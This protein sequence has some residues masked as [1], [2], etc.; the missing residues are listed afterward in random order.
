MNIDT[1]KS[2]PEHTTFVAPAWGLT[3]LIPAGTVLAWGARAIYT[4]RYV[5]QRVRGK[6]KSTTFEPSIDLVWD[7]QGWSSH[8]D[9]PD[10]EA[11][12]AMALWINEHGIPAITRQCRGQ[13][14][15]PSDSVVLAF[16]GSGYAIKASPNSSYGYL[17]IA[18]WRV[19]P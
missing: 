17:Y 16:E 15:T 6:L 9:Q 13:C 14:V 12:K 10:V 1:I 18:A 4:T 5:D 3:A 11:R 2:A 19:E 7:R 8:P